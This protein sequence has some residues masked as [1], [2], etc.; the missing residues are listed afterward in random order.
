MKALAAILFV[1][2]C[3]GAQPS[4]AGFEKTLK[5]NI[6]DFWYPR[7]LDSQ[8]GGYKVNFGPMGEDRGRGPK[9]IVTQSR[10]LWFFA[11]M[12]RAG[13]GDKKQMLDAAAQGYKYLTARMW[14]ARNGGFYWEVD[15]G[16]VKSKANKH[17]YG[18][19]FALYAISEYALAS[20]RR[21][22]LTFAQDFFQLLEK[23]SHD[24]KFGGYREYFTEDWSAIPAGAASYMGPGGEVKLMNTH[25]HVME[26]MT[27]F[28]RASK[29]PLARR[30]LAELVN[31][32]SN[33][34][35]RKN[36]TACT[37]QYNEDWTPRLEGAGARVSYGHD[38]ENIWLLAD[39]LD[40]LEQPVAPFLDLFRS[41]FAYSMRYGW[42]DD[43]GGF[44]YTG[45]FRQPADARDKSWWVQAEALV[46]ALTMYK[47]TRE[48]EY[49]AVFAKTWD[50]LNRYQI[51]WQNGEWHS[52]VDE[53][54]RG[55]GD[56]GNLWKAA[57]HNGRAMIETLA[58]LKQVE[59]PAAEIPVIETGFQPL[60]DGTSLNGWT[61]VHGRGRG[62][63]VENRAIV[64]PQD[65]GGN[66]FTVDEYGDFILRLEW[67][68]WEGGNNGIGVRAPLEG[69]AAYVGME[70]Q[71]LDDEAEVYRKMGLK[72]A[73]YTGSVY[74]VFAAKR[75]AVKR[76]GEWNREEIAVQGRRV[77]VTL[78]DQLILDSNLD[79]AKDAAVLKKHP[80]LARA[81]G[82]IGFLGHGTRVEFRNIRVKRLD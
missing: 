40:A 3:L 6:L 31:I 50:F 53:L 16:G 59:P 77:R 64:C 35:I 70:I 58:L 24:A 9:G 33:A 66:L 22:A 60:F 13:Y 14:D 37:D 32:E 7:S 4:P 8:D 15:A 79:D 20:G 72:P 21:D 48:P 34:V 75:G 2:V 63:I 78:N 29:L 49:W 76:N 80:G 5:S 69:D 12:A 55:S 81:R 67:R 1:T 45:N 51:D 61:L 74:D 30:R 10:M 54:G 65:G 36:L 26:A 73:Q 46:S 11:R 18:Q 38:L 25:L 71:V 23:K 42:D 17:L 47:I 52:S 39:A 82:H 56:K 28:Y 19:A 41:N 43:R 27:T 44:F 68:L 57:Y 62:Y